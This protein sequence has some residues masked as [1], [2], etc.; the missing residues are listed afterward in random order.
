L[1]QDIAWGTDRV[2]AQTLSASRK[3][4]WREALLTE[5]DDVDRPEDLTVWERAK[6]RACS[7]AVIIPTLNE[8]DKLERTL[9][10]VRVGQPDE[11]IVVDGGSTDGT[12][13]L[14]RQ[15]GVHVIVAPRGRGRQMNA[16]AKAAVAGQLLFL[17]ADTLPSAGYRGVVREVLGAADTAAGAFGFAIRESIPYRWILER[18]VSAR[19]RFLGLPYGDQGLFLRRDLFEAIGGYAEWPLLEDVEILARLKAHGRVVTVSLPASTSGRRWLSLGVWSAFWLNQRIMWGYY[20]GATVE[21][22]ARMYF[23]RGSGNAGAVIAPGQG[24][25]HVA[26]PEHRK[27]PERPNRVES[28]R[29]DG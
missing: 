20:R 2:L 29:S 7:L 18:G 25:S 13:A 6:Q 26:G 23:S 3:L 27:V 16:G 1:F 5:L 12:V 15:S 24:D 19:C 14:A 8:A 9:A 28:T 10:C 17:H 4:G 21:R 22:L 11:V